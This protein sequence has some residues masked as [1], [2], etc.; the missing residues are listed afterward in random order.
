M[1]QN[2]F[3]FAAFSTIPQDA[4]AGPANSVLRNPD[5]KKRGKEKRTVETRSFSKMT[6]LPDHPHRR[7][8]QIRAPISLH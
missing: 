4:M 6:P 1:L 7:L 5:G 3:F 2:V 8:K